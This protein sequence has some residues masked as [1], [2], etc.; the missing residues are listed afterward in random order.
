MVDFYYQKHFRAEDGQNGG[1]R[2]CAGKAGQDLVVKVPRGT[3]IRDF[4]TNKVIADM[5]YPDDR[6]I[7]AQEL[8]KLQ[9]MKVLKSKLKN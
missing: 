2:H 8:K 4:E 9:M 1:K 7:V 5:F 6:K 3:I